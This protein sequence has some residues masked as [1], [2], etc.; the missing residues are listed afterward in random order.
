MSD[1]LALKFLHIV[2]LAYWL[3]GDLGV[4]YSSYIVANRDASPAVRV[5]A[6]KT[7]FALDQAPRVCMTMM[8]PLGVHLAWKLGVM[9]FDSTVMMLVWV[10]AFAWL[11]SVVF[12]HSG[13]N[14]TLKALLTKIDYVFRLSVIAVLIGAGVAALALDLWPAPYWVA[15]KMI[16]F[17]VMM[18]MGLIIRVLLKDFG[19][20][21]AGLIGGAPT[22]ADNDAIDRSLGRTRP[23]VLS[24]WAGLLLSTALG[25]H[26]L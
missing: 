1:F 19:P 9:P 18:S 25:I 6:A 14:A 22:D 2:G 10:I 26:L 20:A 4:F 13:K 23:F 17:G 7:L 11:A 15:L 3:G 21:F 8:L 5:S 24:I 16:I 12:L